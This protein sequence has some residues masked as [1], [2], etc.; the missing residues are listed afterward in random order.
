MSFI[1]ELKRRNVVRVGI[2]YVIRDPGL[3]YL[4]FDNFSFHPIDAD[5]RFRA[6]LRN[7]KFDDLVLYE[8]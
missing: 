1:G 2:A 5:P 8:N 7:M 6:F 3:K 4:L